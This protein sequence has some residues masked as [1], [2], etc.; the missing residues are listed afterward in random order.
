MIYIL[1][2]DDSVPYEA[3]WT[4]SIP[5]KYGGTL[6]ELKMDFEIEAEKHRGK[7]ENFV[8][9]GITFSVKFYEF[10]SKKWHYVPPRF[11]TIESWWEE[12]QLGQYNDY[13]RKEILDY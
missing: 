2:F 13:Q 5:I 12:F 10:F 11:Y 3:S 6:E 8:F 9:R 4:T 7:D 1:E